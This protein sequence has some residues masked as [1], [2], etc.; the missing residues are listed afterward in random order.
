MDDG[1]KDGQVEYFSYGRARKKRE[2]SMHTRS[3]PSG[4]REI[5]LGAAGR[6]ERS[7]LETS[8]AVLLNERSKSRAWWEVELWKNYMCNG[9]QLWGSQKHLQ[10]VL[11][12][13][14][15]ASLGLPSMYA[16]TTGISI[17]VL[18]LC[19]TQSNSA[20]ILHGRTIT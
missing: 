16:N 15:S 19:G 17:Y 7:K 2:G 3:L 9:V 5:D 4:D 8:A 12:K 6:T 11:Q 20:A 13:K 14:H 10:S 1:E 18:R